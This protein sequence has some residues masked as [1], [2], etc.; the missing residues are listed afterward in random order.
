MISGYPNTILLVPTFPFQVSD[1][2][3]NLR[4]SLPD[5]ASLSITFQDIILN[6]VLTLQ[7]WSQFL[8]LE[9]SIDSVADSATMEPK[10]EGE[11]KSMSQ[12][13]WIWVIN[14]SEKIE[15][16]RKSPEK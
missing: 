11:K 5:P 8:L 12:R 1:L 6:K 9:K 2:H 13:R 10:V 3:N 16:I 4:L 15:K 7:I 14:M